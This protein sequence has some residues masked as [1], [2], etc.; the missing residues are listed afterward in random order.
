[1]FGRPLCTQLDLLKDLSSPKAVK[2]KENTAKFNTGELV[3][4]QNFRNGPKWVKRTVLASVGQIFF[5]KI[6]AS[7]A[8]LSDLLPG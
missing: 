6:Q 8:G 7:K 2:E 5:Y 3:R 4:V 1:M